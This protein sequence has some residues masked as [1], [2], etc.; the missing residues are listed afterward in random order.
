M[1]TADC[2]KV[3]CLPGSQN[4]PFSF[5]GRGPELI[6]RVL[7]G[8]V[9]VWGEEV[10]KCVCPGTMETLESEGKDMDKTQDKHRG[11]YLLNFSGVSGSP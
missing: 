3:I 10:G 5:R 8:S 2:V 1:R 6:K 4:R 7:M 9:P 11:L